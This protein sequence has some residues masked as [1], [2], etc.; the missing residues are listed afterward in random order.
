LNKKASNYK[1]IMEALLLANLNNLF[2]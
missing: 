2:D 1:L